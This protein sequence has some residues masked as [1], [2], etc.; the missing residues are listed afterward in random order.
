MHAIINKKYF[1]LFLASFLSIYFELVIIRYLSSEIRVF[2]YLKNLPLIASFLGIGL[3]MILGEP[4]KILKNIFPFVALVLFLIISHAKELR[5]THIP[6][7]ESS[8]LLMGR[9]DETFSWFRAMIRYQVM[10]LGISGFIILFFTVIGGFVGQYLSFFKPLKGYTINLSASLVGI[11]IFTL[12]SFWYLPPIFWIAFGLL[13]LVPFYIKKPIALTIFF[14][15]IITMGFPETNVYWSPYYRISLE[16]APPIEETEK[17][18][19]YLVDVNYDYHQKMVDLSEHKKKYFTFEPFRSALITYDFPYRFVKNPKN[20]LIVGAGSGNDVS[21]ALRHGAKHIDA[22]EIDPV[23][24]EL[25]KKYHPESPYG[26]PRV[27][28]FNDDARAFFHK[29]KNKYDLIIYGYL[30]AHTLISSFSSVRLDEYVYTVESFREAKN[31][32]AQDGTLIAAFASGETFVTKRLYE[33]IKKAFGYSPYT[34][35]TQYDQSGVVFVESNKRIPINF[36]DLPEKGKEINDKKSI[37]V[38]TDRWPFLYLKNRVLPIPIISILINFIILAACILY[39][40]R[41]KISYFKQPKYLHLFFMGAGFLLLETKGIT[42]LSLLY[43]STW[44]VNSLVIGSFLFM[45]LIA[46]ILTNHYCVPLKISYALLFGLLLINL[47]FPYGLLL[48]LPPLLKIFSAA[49][50]VGLPVFFSSLIFSHAFK[51]IE[52]PSAGLG[53][54]LFGAVIG[55]ALENTVMIGGIT[56][57]GVLAGMLYGMSWFFIKDN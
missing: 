53:L 51:N 43:G 9:F 25:G 10:V 13:C 3:G 35:F 29:T 17:T 39:G 23:I 19:V 36:P 34:Y 56:L 37:A 32:L 52:K 22:V 33:N 57:L 7:P 8:Y 47:F 20:V 46:N 26:S 40:T 28:I 55:G 2:A 4:K 18:N 27:S 42:E 5:L 15:I 54:N 41:I 45:G 44:M 48:S 6:M 12:L 1:F 11:I 30:D 24:I 21:S 49:I 16:K 50:I 31:L 14:L 38:T